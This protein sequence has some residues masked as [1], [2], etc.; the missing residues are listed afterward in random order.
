[1]AAAVIGWDVG[2]F[3]GGGGAADAVMLD[4]AW[5]FQFQQ[6]FFNGFHIYRRFG[7]IPS[8]LGSMHP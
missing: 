2:Q 6:Q 7:Q 3:C 1:M 5:I 8:H 4:N